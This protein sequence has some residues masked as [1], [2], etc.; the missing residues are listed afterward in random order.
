MNT[1]SKISRPRILRAASDRSLTMEEVRA[2]APAVFQ[3]KAFHTTS[4]TYAYLPTHMVLTSMLK[5]GF[6]VQEVAQARPYKKDRD[7]FAKH[8]LRLRPPAPTG[9]SGKPKVHDIIPEL[10]LVNA[11]DGTARYYLYAGLYRYICSNGMMVGDTFFSMSVAHR[12]GEMVQGLVL[13]GSYKIIKESFPAMLKQVKQMQAATM[14]PDQLTRFA[15][16]AIALR[17]PGE[18]TPVFAPEQLLASR[19]PDDA[20]NSVWQVLNRVQENIIEGGFASQSI[21]FQRR[22]TIRAVERVDARVNINRG[23]WKLAEAYL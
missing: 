8:M 9:R 5:E 21:L 23:L 22:T 4:D 15:T 2:C 10:V 20:G 19:R 18:M 1:L 3:E 13:E 17:Y 12:G 14:R 11:H 16:D 7:P 6:T